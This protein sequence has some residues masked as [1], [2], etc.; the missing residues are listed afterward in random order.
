MV[1]GLLHERLSILR[2]EASF[3]PFYLEKDLEKAE[4]ASSMVGEGAAGSSTEQYVKAAGDLANVDLF[5]PSDV[6]FVSANGDRLGRVPVTVGGLL[7]GQYRILER[8]ARVGATIVADGKKHREAAYNVGERELIGWLQRSGYEEAVAGSG[9]WARAKVSIQE[10][11]AELKARGIDFTGCIEKAELVALLSATAAPPSERQREAPPPKRQR[12]PASRVLI[13]SWNLN[14][15]APSSAKSQNQMKL[16]TMYA[17]LAATSHGPPEVLALQETLLFSPEARSRAQELLPGFVWHGPE[18]SQASFD[19]GV[20]LLV[21]QDSTLAG[22]RLIELPWDDENRVIAYD[23]GVRGLL[24]AVYMP[25]ASGGAA[26]LTRRHYYVRH[27]A[28]FLEAHASR[29]LAVVGDFNVAPAASD[30]SPEEWGRRYLAW[31]EGAGDWRRRAAGLRAAHAEMLERAGLVD[32]WRSK[33]P[34]EAACARG[35]FTQWQRAKQPSASADL[36]VRVDHVLVPSARLADT[37]DAIIY[38][39][40]GAGVDGRYS[41]HVPVGVVLSV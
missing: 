13:A 6:V 11:K 8:V 27:L 15:A 34:D 3:H 9:R 12:V 14:G 21:R 41:D 26:R 39:D 25:A 4:G 36:F 17:E 28:E 2:G 32:A 20:A 38:S 35:G 22:G 33:H 1:V 40:I 10:L 31:P 7:N 16:P 24:V 30:C 29:I 18:S 5:S 19:R 23:A 37:M